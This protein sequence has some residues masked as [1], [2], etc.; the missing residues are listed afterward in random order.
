M[1]SF[2]PPKT[3]QAPKKKDITWVDPAV[4][5]GL[6]KREKPARYRDPGVTALTFEAKLVVGALMV[7]RG[8][9]SELHP[10]G[11]YPFPV[12]HGGFAR[13]GVVLP[14]K[15]YVI[16]AGAVRCTERVRVN[17]E[18]ADLEVP[19]HTFIGPTGRFILHDLRL[20]KHT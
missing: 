4:G 20:V 11:S 12:M 15:V 17:G 9:L 10:M 18:L 19:K 14:H 7:T 5:Y 8:R 3:R 16:Y 6:T 1:R 2:G 13:G